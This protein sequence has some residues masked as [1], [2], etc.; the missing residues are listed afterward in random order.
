MQHTGDELKL[1]F[2]LQFGDEQPAMRNICDK[3]NAFLTVPTSS[4]HHLSIPLD[5]TGYLGEPRHVIMNSPL[6][7]GYHVEIDGTTI[8]ER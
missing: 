6:A 3:P 7:R 4:K 1:G 2:N 8:N 5:G